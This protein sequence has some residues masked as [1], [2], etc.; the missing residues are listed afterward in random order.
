MKLTSEKLKLKQINCF[1]QP[2]NREKQRHP[3]HSTVQRQS[4][5]P[6]P[7]EQQQGGGLLRMVVSNS[8]EN[9]TSQPQ[10]LLQTG[11]RRHD[12]SGGNL[13]RDWMQVNTG[14]EQG[15]PGLDTVQKG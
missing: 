10:K 12:S 5:S 6:N 13:G 14:L 1:F 2:L 8:E 7:S 4:L 3:Y 15:E 11:P 9:C